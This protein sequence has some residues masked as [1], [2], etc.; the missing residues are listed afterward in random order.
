MRGLRS[1]I[2][3]SVALKSRT[4]LKLRDELND[5]IIATLKETLCRLIIKQWQALVDW[6]NS[7]SVRTSPTAPYQGGACGTCLARIVFYTE[8]DGLSKD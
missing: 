7:P 6:G 3:K 4:G 8:P 2:P 5:C 1:P